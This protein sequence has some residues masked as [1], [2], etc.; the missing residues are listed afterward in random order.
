MSIKVVLTLSS[1]FLVLVIGG[2]TNVV[3]PNF[4]QDQ[5]AN[6]LVFGYIQVETDGSNPRG[7]PTHV[8]FIAMT[9]TTTRER[10]RVD[11]HSDSDVFSL[12]LPVGTYSVDRVQFNEGPFMYES[13][14]QLEFHVPEGKA[15]YLGVWQFAVETP[16]TIRHVRIQIAEG[17]QELPMLFSANL[18]TDSTPIITVLP[19]PEVFE[20]RVFTVAPYPKVK[21]FYRQ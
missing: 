2:C 21:Y 14:V 11:V 13:H 15:V 6:E 8:R 19:K 1:L 16:R 9:E 5:D 3:D 20:T 18:V 17:D 10:F 7:Y 12:R 4:A